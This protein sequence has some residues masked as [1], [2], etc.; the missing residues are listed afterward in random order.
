VKRRQCRKGL[1]SERL[2]QLR[3]DAPNLNWSMD[4]VIDA[5]ATG[6]RIKNLT[7]VDDFKKECLTITVAFG[8]SGV[9]VT[10]NLD[11][12]AL[13]RSYLVTVGINQGPEFTC[14]VLNQWTF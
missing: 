13:F 12:I 6:R 1:A 5:L 11:S 10:R 8:I 2:P 9:Q 14:C 4:F 7:C 3:P